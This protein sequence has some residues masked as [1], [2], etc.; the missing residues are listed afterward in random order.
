MRFNVFIRFD[1]QFVYGSFTDIFY[2]SNK[3]R[4]LSIP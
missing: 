1:V 2:I 3:K 4:Y